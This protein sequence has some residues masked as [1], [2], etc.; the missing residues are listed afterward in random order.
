M[1]QE[2]TIGKMKSGKSK[3][4]FG[5]EEFRN[6]PNDIIPERRCPI[7]PTKDHR[8]SVDVAMPDASQTP[9]P[10]EGKAVDPV[11]P[12]TE[13]G[14]GSYVSAPGTDPSKRRRI[15]QQMEARSQLD[16]ALVSIQRMLEN[17]KVCR[18]CM[19]SEHATNEW[20]N[21]PGQST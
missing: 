14:K 16:S 3:G 9:A 2:Q 21:S 11:T 12:S 10:T 19:S 1:P 8:I 7:M 13:A 6:I 20:E 4:S 17:N 18:N 5:F 15:T